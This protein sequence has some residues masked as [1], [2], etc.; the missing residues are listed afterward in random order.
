LGE[1]LDVLPYPEWVKTF[2]PLW[3][4]QYSS[5]PVQRKTLTEQQPKTVNNLIGKTKAI[6]WIAIKRLTENSKTPE[7]LRNY[8]LAKLKTEG[9]N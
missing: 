9:K 5:I 2:E 4:Q 7:P 1:E 3:S 8:W 6:N